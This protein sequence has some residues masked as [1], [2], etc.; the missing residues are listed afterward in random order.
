MGSAV[1]VLVCI[2]SA[3]LKSA[4]DPDPAV[5]SGTSGSAVSLGTPGRIA[6]DWS[7]SETSIFCLRDRSA[8]SVLANSTSDVA[9]TA[10]SSTAPGR[11]TMASASDVRLFFQLAAECELV[12]TG[13]LLLVGHGE[14]MIFGRRA[15]A[16]LHQLPAND[17]RVDLKVS[18]I[19]QNPREAE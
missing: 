3:A 19:I 12:D 18:K 11:G 16:N 1:V 14:A 9:S 8:S 15:H 6:A 4:S 17:D 5:S 13:A 2:S 10:T 7:S